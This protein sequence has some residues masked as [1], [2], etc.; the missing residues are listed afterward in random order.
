MGRFSTRGRAAARPAAPEWWGSATRPGDPLARG[1]SALAAGRRRS[2]THAAGATVSRRAQ[3]AHPQATR[4]PEARAGT[5]CF[6]FSNILVPPRQAAP[7]PGLPLLLCSLDA[8]QDE[9]S[10]RHRA[11]GALTPR[12]AGSVSP[13]TCP[14]SENLRPFLGSSGVTPRAWEKR[15]NLPLP[16]SGAVQ[17]TRSISS[18][19]P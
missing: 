17:A 11:E 9:G 15:Q 13:P 16:P 3:P 2:L 1:P 6:P 7:P 19:S 4:S 5:P 14:G 8:P 18:F 12:C 10:P